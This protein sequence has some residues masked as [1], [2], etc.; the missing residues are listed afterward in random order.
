MAGIASSGSPALAQQHLATQTTLT[1]SVAQAQSGTR[2]TFNVHVSPIGSEA[3]AEGIVTIV[4]GPREIGSAVLN[5]DGDATVESTGLM[6][7]LHAVRALYRGSDKLSGSVS[8]EANV[9]SETSTAPTFTASANPTTVAVAQGNTAT[10]TI[11]LTPQNG[12]SN[13]VSLSC[14]QLPSD[15]T[16]AFL[17]VNVFVSGTTATTSVLSIETYGPTG[18][19]AMVRKHAS[20]LVLAFLFPGALCLAGIGLRRR[21]WLTKSWQRAGL[22]LI[23]IAGLGAMGGCSQRY[24]YLN[25]PPVASPGTALGS[26]TITIEAQA[27]SGVAITTQTTNI[28]LTVQAPAS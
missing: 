27:V 3:N 14:T 28:V 11:T 8:P 4:E 12:Y 19:D 16:C 1:T 9:T 18:P 10:Y 23:V 7:G 24:H 25:R 5:A 2:A 26:S 17:P 20:T 6:P 21:S 13:Y 15:T 22:V